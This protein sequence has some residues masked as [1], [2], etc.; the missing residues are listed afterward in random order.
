MSA[1]RWWWSCV[2]SGLIGAVGL[3]GCP[4]PEGPKPKQDQ[5]TDTKDSKQAGPEEKADESHSAGTAKIEDVRAAQDRIKEIPKAKATM[6]DGKLVEIVIQDGSPLTAEDFL[7]FGRLT[8]LKKF[9]VFNCRALNDEMAANLADL[10]DLASLALTNTV[11]NDATVDLIVKSFPNLTELDL[12]SNT[13]MTSGVF[14]TISQLSHLQR[15]T[16]VQNRFNELSTRGLS[17]LQDLRTLDMRGNMEAGDMTLEVVADLPKLTAFKHRST[18]VS[19][20]GMEHLTRNATLESL[21]VQ[22][23]TITDQSGPHL[24]KLGKLTQ[25][26]V[27]RCQGFGTEG[28]LALKGMG[29]QRLTLRDLPNVDDRALEVL[30][31]LPKLRRLYLHEI[32]S[33]SDNGLKN[34]G[35][36]KTLEVLD[37]WSVP[38]MT[39]A[40]LD[41]I[42]TLPNLKELSIRST[43]VTDTG[44]EKLLAMQSVQSLTFKD[45]GSVTPEGLKKLAS[46]KWTKL[47]VGSSSDSGDAAP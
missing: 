28:V 2:A 3:T 34:L 38:Q 44:I 31:D 47:D 11:I 29:L 16:L 45:N 39:D 35:A 32:A 12:S 42:A 17:K 7:L 23:F 43:G 24:A 1:R 18:A 14:K 20:Y 9:H 37:I 33:L 22:D 26:E 13:N 46:R 6:Q 5:G 36:L 30:T 8:D 41:V 27:F 15:L 4:G 21:L 19:D 40:T 10:K 25:L